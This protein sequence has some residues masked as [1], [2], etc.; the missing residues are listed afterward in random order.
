MNKHFEDVLEYIRACRMYLGGGIDDSSDTEEPNIA[1]F[2]FK[3]TKI[4][5]N[6]PIATLTCLDETVV[7]I[8]WGDGTKESG[9]FTEVTHTY[10]KAAAGDT[11]CIKVQCENL[12][13]LLQVACTTTPDSTD[14]I[15]PILNVTYS[16]STLLPMF[17]LHTGN[18][19]D[20]AIP[21]VQ[22]G[23]YK[24]YSIAEGFFNIM[25]PELSI[26][27]CGIT[28]TEYAASAQ[29]FQQ[30]AIGDGTSKQLAVDWGDLTPSTIM[31][32]NS[33]PATF[34]KVLTKLDTFG[35]DLRKMTATDLDTL[36]TNMLGDSTWASTK[37]YILYEADTLADDTKAVL[38]KHG[39]VSGNIT[40]LGPT[41]LTTVKTTYPDIWNLYFTELDYLT[42]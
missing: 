31:Y 35:V 36:L 25:A 5:A 32:M 14:G 30:V 34:S 24:P 1:S 17:A 39:A 23:A 22:I 13:R 42:Q 4:A 3:V 26:M 40:V 19:E 9:S 6:P 11:I 7:L 8:D 37:I 15:M 28:Q 20:L 41:G 2:T 18:P 12:K 21:V 38:V 16:G 33:K 10:S 29:I 27:A